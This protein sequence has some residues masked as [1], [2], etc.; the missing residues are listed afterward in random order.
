MNNSAELFEICSKMQTNA[1][2]CVWDIFPLEILDIVYIFSYFQLSLNFQEDTI[3]KKWKKIRSNQ[4]G[5]LLSLRRYF[6]WDV[7]KHIDLQWENESQIYRTKAVNAIVLIIFIILRI[8]LSVSH[9]IL[10]E[11][12]HFIEISLKISSFQVGGKWSSN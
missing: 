4:V 2:S 9:L 12:R 3:I 10:S 8:V 1:V 5:Y 6:L 11:I 7:W